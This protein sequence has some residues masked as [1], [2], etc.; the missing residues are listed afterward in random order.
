MFGSE[1][2]C[3]HKVSFVPQQNAFVFA[4]DKIAA[5]YHAEI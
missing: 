5:L 2:F 4:L 1:S 3:V